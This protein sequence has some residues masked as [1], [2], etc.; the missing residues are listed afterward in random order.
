MVASLLFIGMQ[1]VFMILVVVVVVF[2]PQKLPEIAR[3][4]GRAARVLRK[5][6]NDIKREILDPVSEVSPFSEVTKEIDAIK[7]EMTTAKDKLKADLKSN[8][9]EPTKE[10]MA[11]LSKEIDEVTE[12]IRQPIIRGDRQ[13]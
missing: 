6:S 2:G 11:H 9:L 3:D 5:V 4:L 13:K 1:E 7:E 8:I 12:S 10:G